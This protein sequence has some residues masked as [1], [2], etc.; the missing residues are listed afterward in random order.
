VSA[1]LTIERLRTFFHLRSGILRAVDGVDL[2]LAAGRTLG[3]VGESG[4]GKSMTALSVMRLVEP[5][6]RIESGSRIIFKGR[7]LITM[8]DESLRSIRGNE[9]SMIFQEPMSSLN[10]VYTV[11]DQIA[12]A[13][14]THQGLT[15]RQAFKRASEMLQLVEIPSANKRIH[16]FPH[17]MSGGMRQRVMIAMALSCNPKLLIADEPTTALDVTIQAQILELMRDLRDRLSMSIMLI[18]H[19]LGVV[20][21]MADDV[22]V[23]YAGR[24]VERGPTGITLSNP[25]HPYTE[26]LMRSI[27]VVGMS[28]TEPLQVIPGIVPSGL[29]WPEGCRFEPRCRYAFSKCRNDDP[30]LFDVG[31]Q[32]SA[33]WLCE[34][35]PRHPNLGASP[36]RSSGSVSDPPP[37]TE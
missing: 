17:Q 6:G 28:Q 2:T 34:H 35:G 22:A 30:T 31:S 1:L 3:L 21:E 24:V 25:Q 36:A 19:D 13:V 9:I 20:A 23:M 4:C 26:A 32:K 10:P 14:W 15:R 7:N 8:D 16:E 11:G 27:P 18:T 33:C 12:E 37:S 5:P 29:H